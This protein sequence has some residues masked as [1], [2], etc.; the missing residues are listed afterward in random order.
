MVLPL[1]LALIA[2]IRIKYTA[3]IKLN[4]VHKIRLII[5]VSNFDEH[6]NKIISSSVNKSVLC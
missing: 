6:N 4:A 2:K 3:R 1:Q 5:L